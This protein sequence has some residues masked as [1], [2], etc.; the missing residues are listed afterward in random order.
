MR[1]SQVFML[2]M[3]LSESLAYPQTPN[4]SPVPVFHDIAS[5]AGLTASHISSAEK[6][7]VIESMSGGIGLFDCDNDGKLD[8]VVN[9]VNGGAQLFH[10]QLCGGSSL[11][12]DLFW[13]G[14]HNSRAIG[15]T[16][17]L[18]TDTANYYR[19]VKAASGYLSG[20]PARIHF[21]YPQD[22]V[23][24]KLQ[25]RWPD[26]AQSVVNNPAGNSILEVTRSG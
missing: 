19:D 17:I 25:I 5:Q 21:G 22:A 11:Q 3:L 24:R 12:V 15:S 4:S 6:R 26:G 18:S 23:L 8:I 13:P 14:S 9:N 20:D 1:L 16:L 7:Y 10:N 2:L